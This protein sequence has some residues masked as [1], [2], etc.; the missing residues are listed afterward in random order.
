MGENSPNP[1]TLFSEE[2]LFVCPSVSQRFPLT[3]LS[4]SVLSVSFDDKHPAKPHM[5][6]YSQDPLGPPLLYIFCLSILSG[7]VFFLKDLFAETEIRFFRSSN[8]LCVLARYAHTYSVS[9]PGL[10]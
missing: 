5:L 10:C 4:L 7:S 9:E 6:R 8:I 3:L 1:V 2:F